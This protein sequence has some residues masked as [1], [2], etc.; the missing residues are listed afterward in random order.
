SGALA[1]IGAVVRHQLR[2]HA[3]RA[4]QRAGHG[5]L[6]KSRGGGPTH[7]LRHPPVARRP[8]RRDFPRRVQLQVRSTHGPHHRARAM[9]MARSSI[10]SSWPPTVFIRPSS[11]SISV[12]RT[13]YLLAARFANNRKDEYTPA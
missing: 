9:L 7:P 13:P 10:I 4:L 1:A 3:A 12:E 5:L 8:Q 2:D 11:T 6:R